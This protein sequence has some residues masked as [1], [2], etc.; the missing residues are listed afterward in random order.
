MTLGERLSG[1]GGEV[2]RKKK[3]KRLSFPDGICKTGLKKKKVL[4]KSCSQIKE[5]KEETLE[6]DPSR[7]GKRGIGTHLHF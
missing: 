2:K 3:G 1:E 6:K 4:G 5:E 7:L